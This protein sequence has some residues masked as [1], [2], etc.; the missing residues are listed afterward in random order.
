MHILLGVHGAGKTSV[1]IT[2]SKNGFS[3][4]PEIAAEIIERKVPWRLP[5]SFEEAVIT[6][7]LE[8]DG[9]PRC[10]SQPSIRALTLQKGGF[11]TVA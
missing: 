2:V 9:L 3:F 10:Q 8:R 4:F 7:E 6:K 1:G 11:D 5:A